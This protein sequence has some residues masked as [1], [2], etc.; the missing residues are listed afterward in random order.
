MNR[1]EVPR[2]RRAQ[3]WKCDGE[4]EEGR[5]DAGKWE[6][7]NYFAWREVVD[8]LDHFVF[9]LVVHPLNPYDHPSIGHPSNRLDHPVNL[10]DHPANLLDDPSNLVDDLS[11][12][13]PH[14]DV[15]SPD[16][17]HDAAEEK[18]KNTSSHQSVRNRSSLSPPSLI[19]V[20][21][22]ISISS[23]SDKNDMNDVEEEGKVNNLFYSSSTRANENENGLSFVRAN[24]F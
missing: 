14:H 21:I 24:D 4:E 1:V 15:L 22:S 20:A 5:W 9:L 23:S 3:E 18:G 19:V 6:S 8:L 12:P 11:N 13:S 2:A 17:S 7:G 10:L 16:C